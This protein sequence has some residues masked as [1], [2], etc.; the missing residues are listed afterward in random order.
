MSVHPYK[1]GIVPAIDH[2]G[3]TR[4]AD[5]RELV[6]NHGILMFASD[7]MLADS[8]DSMA[9]PTCPKCR[10]PMALLN[11]QAQLWGCRFCPARIKFEGI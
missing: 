1:D 9:A 11:R 7:E 6:W 10:T 5:G 3:N 2:F 4:D 8:G